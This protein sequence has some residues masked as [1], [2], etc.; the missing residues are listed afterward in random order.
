MEIDRPTYMVQSQSAYLYGDYDTV[1]KWKKLVERLE[2]VV[3]PTSSLRI[4]RKLYPLLE[5][6][7]NLIKETLDIKLN[8][9][10]TA[11]DED[12]YFNRMFK[13]ETE[14]FNVFYKVFHS[15]RDDLGRGI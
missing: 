15:L 12:E 1:D 14:F 5:S 9:A 3:Q 4:S 11:V 8:A 10:K 6:L 7:R 2:P 13:T